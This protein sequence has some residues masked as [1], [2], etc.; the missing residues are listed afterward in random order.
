MPLGKLSLRR[1]DPDNDRHHIY[2][3]HGTYYAHFTVHFGYRKRRIRVSLRTPR[4][5]EA[6]VRRDELLTRIALEGFEVPDRR[7]HR[8]GNPST[9]HT[10]P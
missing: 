9:G 10:S 3:N 7:P 5:E 8:D 1:R 6:K 2:D 4:I